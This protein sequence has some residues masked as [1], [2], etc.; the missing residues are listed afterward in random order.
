[1]TQLQY[2]FD[3]QVL[4]FFTIIFDD[5]FR[6]ERFS[7][8]ISHFIHSIYKILWMRK[9]ADDERINLLKFFLLHFGSPISINNWFYF[10]SFNFLPITSS[11][12]SIH[13][14]FSIIIREKKKM[15][16]KKIDDEDEGFVMRFSKHWL[17]LTS[18]MNCKRN[19]DVPFKGRAHFKCYVSNCAFIF[20]SR[21]K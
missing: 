13:L 19:K 3:L 18:P 17:I 15:K 2:S 7:I 5:C 8:S 1:M 9:S 6:I 10:F 20:L 14:S 21:I 4:I 16:M 11:N 12:L